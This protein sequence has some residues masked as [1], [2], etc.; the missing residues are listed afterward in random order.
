MKKITIFLMC[1]IIGFSFVGCTNTDNKNE[2]AKAAL[3]RVLNKEQDFTFKSLVSDK[4]TEENL[5]KFS[6][7]TE[8]NFM[9]YFVPQGYTYIDFDSDS[10]DELLIIDV[11]LRFF[12]ILRYDSEKVNGYI[13]ENIS[14]QDIKTDGS[15]L[16]LINKG[17]T[18]ISQIKF[19][20]L[21]C[22]LSDLAYWHDETNTFKLN[23][24]SATEEEVEDY[25]DDWNKNTTKV[26]WTQID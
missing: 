19:D 7:A 6:F 1:L 13:L 22:E 3:Q 17:Y 20:G 9:N 2:V 12:L 10:I 26:S 16:V 21:E 23:G 24:K 25:R 14:L 11:Q 18:T 15:F 5:E 8:G 4:V